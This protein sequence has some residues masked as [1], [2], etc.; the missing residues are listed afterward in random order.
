MGNDFSLTVLKEND[1]TIEAGIVYK[2]V[3]VELTL[4]AAKGHVNTITPEDIVYLE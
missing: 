4:G 1:E 3:G 2:D